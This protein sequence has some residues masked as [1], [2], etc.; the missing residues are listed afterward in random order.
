[1][2]KQLS[3]LIMGLCATV[4]LSTGCASKWSLAV[5]TPAEAPQWR[6]EANKPR[7][8]YLE[9]IKGFKE[10]GTSLS[11]IMK[12]VVFGKSGEN[13]LII[14]PVA[15]VVGRDSRIAIVDAG[16]SCVHLYIPSD[17]SYTRIYSAGQEQMRTPVNAAFDD[18][19]RL[20]VSDST[21][22]AIDT[23]DQA[24]KYLASIKSAGSDTLRRPTGLSY[25][26]GQKIL[27]ALDTAANKVYAFGPGRELLFSFGEPGEVEGRFNYP[28]HL[29]TSRDGSLYVTD[30]MNFRV[31]VFGSRGAFRSAFGH[32]G[33]G[34]G[35]FAM[36]KGIAVDRA[37]VIYV[38]DTLFDTI[39]LFDV[40]GAF[41]FTIGGSGSGLGE[42]SMP[43]GVFLDN[44]DRL[45]VCDTY[46][47]RVQVLQVRVVQ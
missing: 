44:Q 2:R 15:V 27:Y 24:G 6:D 42:F 34:S 37:G 7:V 40:S 12:Y 10:N 3:C 21:R 5:D 14:R 20:Y 32:H 19:S 1:M 4:V 36:P 18:E 43:S 31:Q 29:F 30:A 16:C 13:N 39:Q 47:Q 46:N 33:N 38:V 35:D 9:T 23:F 41:L 25:S 45:Y 26:P 22:G 28:T 11:N 8:V 17:Q